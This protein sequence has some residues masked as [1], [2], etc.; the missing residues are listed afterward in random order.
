M[1]SPEVGGSNRGLDVAKSSEQSLQPLR[2][3]PSGERTQAQEFERQTSVNDSMAAV[4]AVQ[5]PTPVAI[6]NT[7]APAI[8]LAQP[9]VGSNPLTA[10][11]DDLIE[12]EWIRK[13]QDIVR[14]T[15]SDPKQQ[16]TKVTELQA[17]YLSKRY[18]KNLEL[19]GE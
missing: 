8:N 13:A 17:D 2:S 10:K 6:A 16:Q 3:E 9:I 1:P 7:D 5:F 12:R 18:G 4:Q 19:S 14:L 11:D 15:R